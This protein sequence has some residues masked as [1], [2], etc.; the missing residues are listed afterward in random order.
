MV[1]DCWHDEER[2]VWYFAAL[3]TTSAKCKIEKGVLIFDF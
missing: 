1:R 2:D 3:R